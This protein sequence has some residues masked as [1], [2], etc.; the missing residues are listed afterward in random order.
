MSDSRAVKTHG[1]DALPRGTVSLLFT[2]IERSTDH[3]RALRGEYGLLLAGYSQVLREAASAY[4]GH[5]VDTQG[6]A[7]F[8]AFP[9]ALDSV[10]AAVDMQR[11]IAAH[12]WPSGAELRVRMSLHTGEP[13]IVD[14]RY[15]GLDVHR[16]ARI[17]SAAHGGQVLLSDS[18]VALLGDGLPSGVGIREVGRIR[19]KG[20]PRPEPVSQL[21]IAGLDCSFAAPQSTDSEPKAGASELIADAGAQTEGFE[22]LLLGPVA[23]RRSGREVPVTAAKHRMILAAL[24]LRVGEVLSTDVLID[25]LW[26]EHPPATATKA[27]QVYVSELRKLIEDD[28]RRPSVLTSIAPGYRLSVARDA[29]DLPRFERL[30]SAGREALAAGDAAQAQQQLYHALSLWRGDPLADFRFEDAFAADI[31]RLEELHVECLVDRYE[32]DLALGEHAR[33]IPELEALVRQY[34]LRERVRGQLMLAL[35]RAGRQ[36]DALAAYQAA[37]EQLVDE[38]GIDPSAPL[39]ELER[40]ILQQDSALA[41]PQ[42]AVAAYDAATPRRTLLVVSQ[43][44]RDLDAV[45]ELATA[46]TSASGAPEFLL[47]RV[48][49]DVPGCDPTARLGEITRTLV[50]HR[51]RL[52]QRGVRVHVAAFVSKD[53]AVDL[54][55]LA[56]HQNAHMVVVDGTATLLDGRFGTIDAMVRSAACDIALHLPRG[57]GRD[58]PDDPVVVPFGGSDHD[59]AALEFGAALARGTGRRLLLAG[60]ERPDAASDASR[61]LATASLIIQ[62]VTGIVPEPVLVS[63]GATELIAIGGAGHFVTGLSAR[64]R[65]EG[66]G[67]VR[68]QLARDAIGPVTFVRRGTRPGLLAPPESVTRFTWSLSARTPA[69]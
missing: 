25:T 58:G 55:K 17:C 43:S 69:V 41:L 36:T 54:E 28:P 47:A 16:A 20:F 39:T 24:G 30:W 56:D 23:A 1:A 42:R 9:R 59:W 37:R 34:P 21:D 32:A 38:F 49:T 66:L 11:G 33:L 12:E 13:D 57:G 6:D 29:V 8:F 50:A 53:P 2:D 3:L 63:P 5:E 45:T 26:R 15:V 4:R 14:G 35:Y 48:V 46:I 61:L 44:S 64:F 67:E 65:E 27:L 62:R 10:F 18:T 7:F 31:R 19:I 60:G 40:R 52:A 51:D 22:L 68:Y